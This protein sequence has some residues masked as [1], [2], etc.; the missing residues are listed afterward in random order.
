MPDYVRLSTRVRARPASADEMRNLQIP[1][2]TP[3]LET[4]S[5]NTDPNGKRIEFGIS[6]F[7]SNRVELSFET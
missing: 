6:S 1:A 4:R 5:V 2:S 3:V 7:A